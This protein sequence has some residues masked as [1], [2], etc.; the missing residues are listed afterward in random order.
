MEN[1]CNQCLISWLIQ[2]GVVSCYPYVSHQSIAV[3]NFSLFGGVECLLSLTK[4]VSHTSLFQFTPACTIT[5]KVS[6]LNVQRIFQNVCKVMHLGHMHHV[7]TS[8]FR[9]HLSVFPIKY[10]CNMQMFA[11]PTV[12]NLGSSDRYSDIHCTVSRCSEY[13]RG[14][15]FAHVLWGRGVV[16]LSNP[17]NGGLCV[18]CASCRLCQFSQP[19]CEMHMEFTTFVAITLLFA[20]YM[21][22]SLASIN[23]QQGVE[24]YLKWNILK[25]SNSASSAISQV[26]SGKK[27]QNCC[28][29]TGKFKN[30]LIYQ[31]YR[32]T[33]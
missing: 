24:P 32:C 1:C 31:V 5:S 10:C 26:Y 14:G 11:C 2:L 12:V 15:Y 20:V 13:P 3:I 33:L 7:F 30:L 8:N 23:S 21:S 28:I 17:V 6:I 27:R 29:I 9:V 4:K 22:A 25:L 16:W 19:V 18:N